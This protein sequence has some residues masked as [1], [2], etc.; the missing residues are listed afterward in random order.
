MWEWVGLY[1][2]VGVA[3]LLALILLPWV[4]DLWDKLRRKKD[5]DT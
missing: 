3:A 2:Q 4:V 5:D 1:I